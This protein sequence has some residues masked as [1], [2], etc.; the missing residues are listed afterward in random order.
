MDAF[1]VA[2][3]VVAMLAVAAAILLFERKRARGIEHDLREQAT[4]HA[5][6]RPDGH[7]DRH[8]EDRSED[9]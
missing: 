4:L 6:D 2:L 9:R 8:P 7:H 1:S 3:T 5:H